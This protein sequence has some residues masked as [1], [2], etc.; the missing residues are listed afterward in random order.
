MKSHPWVPVAI[1]A[2]ALVVSV[3]AWFTSR[4]SA[5]HGQMLAYMQEVQE[6]HS[7]MLAQLTM[8]DAAEMHFRT[9]DMDS[10]DTDAMAAHHD[11]LQ[12]IGDVRSRT[13]RIIRKLES[14]EPTID[15]TAAAEMA[16]L[17]LDQKTL[18]HKLERFI[19]HMRDTC[20]SANSGA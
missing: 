2:L 5:H 14:L 10:N 9:C 18:Q 11:D 7:R 8:I 13:E 1:S 16:Q 15:P 20:R 19:E 17:R 4:E 12:F 6:L 3:F